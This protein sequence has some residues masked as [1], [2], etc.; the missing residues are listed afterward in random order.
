[1]V[2][3]KQQ[4]LFEKTEFRDMLGDMK[5]MKKAIRIMLGL[6]V[7]VMMLS[8]FAG[9]GDSGDRSIQTAP[10]DEAAAALDTTLAAFKTAD[11][12]TINSTSGGETFIQGSKDA[13]GSEEQ[14][15]DV[16][17]IMFGHFDYQLG[18]PEQ[19]DDTHVN[20]PA[21]VS[22]VDMSKAV[23]TWYSDFMNYIMANPSIA[24]DEAAL[25]EK[26]IEMLKS[27]VDKTSEEEG[28]IMTTDV[29]FPMVLEDGQWTIG[30][31][32]ENVPD[33]MVG[34]FMSALEELGQ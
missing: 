1:M 2:E 23:N 20:V 5:H 18:T 22:N 28:G 34:G 17:N 6:A 27:A 21:T 19:V 29:T 25:S 32:D 8:A 30:E 14:T 15:Q 11:M 3:S 16:L 9:C 24:N 33:A 10:A 12:D 31:V 13:F 7:S 4:I 26:N